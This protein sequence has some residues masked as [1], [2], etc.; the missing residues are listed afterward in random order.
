M[1]DP[2]H[3][4]PVGRPGSYFPHFHH[5]SKLI[6]FFN[7]KIIT[8]DEEHMKFVHATGFN[9]FWRGRRQKERM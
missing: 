6:S 7:W 3:A 9:H 5:A 8:M 4:H 2:Q 1:H